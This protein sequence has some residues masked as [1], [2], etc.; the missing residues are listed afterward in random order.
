MDLPPGSSPLSR[1][2]PYSSLLDVI[3]ARIIPALA[4]NTPPGSS[5]YPRSK[6][7]PR[8]RGEYHPQGGQKGPGDG[9][10]PLSRGILARRVASVLWLRIIPALAGNTPHGHTRA[11]DPEDHPRSRGEY[12]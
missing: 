3:A 5:G 1:G 6:D 9:S 10:S 7:H 8:S 4:G 11:T 12:A 2:I